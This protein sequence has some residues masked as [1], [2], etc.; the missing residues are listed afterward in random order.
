MTRFALSFLVIL[1]LVGCG[2]MQTTASY[3][4]D[5][6]KVAAVERAASWQG[7]QVYWVNKPRRVLTGG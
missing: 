2:T 5:L 6:A 1:G 7:V 3:E 4:T